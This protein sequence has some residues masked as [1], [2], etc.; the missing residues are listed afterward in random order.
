MKRLIGSVLGIVGLVVFLM[1]GTA[2][3]ASGLTDVSGVVTNNG[4]PITGAHVTVVCN[5]NNLTDN[6]DTT[7]TYVVQFTDTECPAGAKVTVVATDGSLG[8]TNSGVANALTTR[9]N[10]SIINV[11]LPEFG[12]VTGIG[13]AIVGGGALM[14]IRRR[15]LSEHKA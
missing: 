12:V 11:A 8:G 15:H 13:A 6:T 5:N 14:V 4:Q 9:L 10:V 3:A 2:L 7:G 1:P